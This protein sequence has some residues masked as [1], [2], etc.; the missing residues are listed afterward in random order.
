M[1]GFAF[2]LGVLMTVSLVISGFPVAHAQARVDERVFQQ[3]AASPTGEATFLAFFGSRPDLSAETAMTDR[4]ARKMAVARALKAN[5]DRSQAGALARLAQLKAQGLVSRYQAFFVGNVIS[6]TGRE[7]AVSALAQT[8]GVARIEAE[9]EINILGWMVGPASRPNL[10]PGVDAA[11]SN[12]KQVKAQKAWQLGFRGQGIIVASMDT[13]VRYTHEALRGNYKCGVGGPHANCWLDAISGVLTPYDD[14]QHGTHTTGT[15][16]GR[17]GIGVAKKAKWIACKFLNSGGSGSFT[18]AFECA[19]WFLTMALN[20]D[21]LIFT[22]DVINNSW[23]CGRACTVF[24][25][26][27]EDWLA[28]GIIPQFAIGNAGPSCSTSHGPGEYTNSF[29]AGAVDS[30]D[31][32]AS[33]SSRGPAD[34]SNG[35]TIKPDVSAPGVSIRSSSNGSDTSYSFLSGTS[36]ASPHVAGAAAVVL[37]KNGGL[38][39]AMVRSI[40]EGSADSISNLTCGGSASDNNVYGHGRLN[41]LQAVNDTP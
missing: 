21:T 11:Q 23:S 7:G 5:A 15:M 19:N 29:A 27:V 37:S 34:A 14:N 2:A 22:P 4:A 25:P 39:P 9:G 17:L 10:G 16:A 6:V 41:V 20:N 24:N 8:A 33:F 26:S 31:V 1:R 13:G 40:I 32:I 3:L 30:G 36:M 38:T 35:G 28:A 18:D 12:I